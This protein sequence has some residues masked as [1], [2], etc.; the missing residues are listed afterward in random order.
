[1]FFKFPFKLLTSV[2]KIDEIQGAQGKSFE[3]Y[4]VYGEELFSQGNA[5]VRDFY[6]TPLV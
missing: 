4:R 1:M 2:I 3:P 5:V 6:R